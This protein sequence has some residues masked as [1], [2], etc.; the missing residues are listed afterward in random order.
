MS[1]ENQPQTFNLK[2][3][4]ETLDRMNQFMEAAGKG[5]PR[6]IAEAMHDEGKKPV[7]IE[8][9]VR[10]GFK[11]F[12]KDPERKH[13]TVAESGI[14]AVAGG[15]ATPKKWSAEPE[16][17][18]P[19]G[20][21]G[22]FLTSIV[23]W[24]EDVKGSAG[25]TVYVQTVAPVAKASITS[26]TEPTFTASTIS[27]VPVTLTQM[28]HGFYL[29]KAQVEDIQDGVADMMIQQSK[30]A[31]MR[32]VDDYFLTALQAD[33]GNCAAGTVTA[34]GVLA[35]TVLATAWGSVMAGSYS[36]AAVIAHPVPY[37]S[38]LK[39]AQFVNAATRG[40]KGAIDTAKI[41]NYL[42][43]EI[44]PLIQ[45]TLDASGGTYRTYMMS[46]GALVGAIKRDM[47]VEKE[48]YVKD[49]RNYVVT[50]IRFGGAVVHTSGIAYIETVNG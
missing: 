20:A 14:G 7:E 36:P 1:E 32:G 29:T 8:E 21:D 37:A 38:L 39:D 46:K 50:A 34:G 30:N 27:S 22:Y 47:E 11:E 12:L 44:V 6:G 9:K 33:A 13:F 23:Q 4:T 45:G 18:S 31:I 19:A 40:E 49:Q 16:L 41:P 43:M 17:L 48:Y 28:G 26:G 25:D 2:K 15:S 10:N 3:L 42:G 5:E 24:K 35:A